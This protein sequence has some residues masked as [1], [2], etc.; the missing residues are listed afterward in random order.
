MR[1]HVD[2]SS[3]HSH[4]LELQ[5]LLPDISNGGRGCRVTGKAL[6]TRSERSERSVPQ[7]RGLRPLSYF[8]QTS[9]A[10]PEREVGRYRQSPFD[11][12]RR[13]GASSTGKRGI[14][15]RMSASDF[16]AW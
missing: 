8:A 14:F 10:G 11:L 13:L 1:L 6:K 5:F 4:E 7:G 9:P 3:N 16:R 15:F 2:A 12:G